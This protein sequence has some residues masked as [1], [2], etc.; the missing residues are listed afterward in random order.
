MTSNPNRP[1]IKQ[2]LQI[3]LENKTVSQQLPQDRPYI[4]ARVA[5]LK[6]DQ[7]L[8]DLDKKQVFGKVS[9]FVYAIECQKR[10]LPHMH[11]LIIMTPGDKIHQAEELDDLISSEI[12]QHDDLELRE[13]VLKWMIH[14]P[15]GDLNTN[16]ICMVHKNGRTKCRFDFPKSYQEVTSLVDDGK[17]NYRRR[18]NPQL[19]PNSPQFSHEHAVYRK[20]INGRRITRD[21]RHVAPYNAK[22]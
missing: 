20:N 22:I 9:A 18:Y 10:G 8:E 15:C 1:E 21:N 7:I 3:H 12:P 13:L 14:N 2:A 6:F 4:V 11:L 16:A 17:P 19:D 5:K